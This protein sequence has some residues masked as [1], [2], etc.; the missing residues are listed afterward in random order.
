MKYFTFPCG[1]RFPID[2]SLPPIHGHPSII[3]DPNDIPLDCPITYDLIGEGKTKGVFQ[4]ESPLGRQWAKRAKPRSIE[5]LAA[6]GSLLRPGCLKSRDERGVSMTE[7]YCRY[8]NGEEDIEIDIE[9]VRPILE[10]TY[11]VMCFQEQAM[12]I[13]QVVA[14]FDLLEVDKLRKCVTGD[15]QF[16]S[17][18]RG[19]IS[20]DRLLEE[21][22]E[23]DEFLVMDENGMQSWQQIEKI[24]FTG[25]Q[26][27]LCVRTDS[28]ARV[29]ATKNHQFLTE[30]GWK[31]RMRL[32]E[33]EDTI[34]SARSVSY[35]GQ[36]LITS[37]IAL[38]IAGIVAE[39]YFV[40]DGTKKVA[41]FTNF[42]SL[43]MSVFIE[44]FEN[45]FGKENYWKSEDGKVISIRVPEQKQLENYINRGLSDTRQLPDVMMG[46]TLESTRKF[47][48]YILACEGGVTEKTG[49]FEFSSKSQK[50]ASQI[51][52][53]LLRFG[54]RSILGEYP[55]S[56][57]YRLTVG[58]VEDQKRLLTELTSMWSLTKV[59]PLKVAVSRKINNYTTDTFPTSIV[60]KL[61]NQYPFVGNGE[62]GSLYNKPISRLRL[63][64]IADKTKDG[65]WSSIVRGN[66][67]YDNVKSIGDKRRQTKTYDFTVAGGKTPY[68]IANGMVIHNSIG[69]KD[70]ATLAKVGEL[71][72]K[73]ATDFGVITKEQAEKLFDNMRKSGRY[74][75]NASHAVSY[76]II[77]YQT[78]HLKA[79]FPIQFFTSYLTNARE[80]QKPLQEIR[81]LVNDA[82]SFGFEVLPP[83]FERLD[84]DFDIDGVAIRFGLSDVK[85]VSEAT[86]KK[87]N[88][89]IEQVEATCE[90]HRTLWTWFDYLRF[91]AD[92]AGIGVSRRMIE[93]GALADYKLDRQKM[94]YELE[95]WD[96]LTDKEKGKISTMQTDN[97]MSAI[98]ILLEIPKGVANAKRKEKVV[99]LL[100]T[101]RNPKRPLTDSQSWVAKV[102]EESLG[103]PLTTSHVEGATESIANTTCAEYKAGKKGDN[104]V[105]GVTIEDAREITIKNGDNRGRKMA[106]L[107]VS[108]QTGSLQDV[109][110]FSEA[111][112]RYKN[113][114]VVNNNV[115]LYGR[116][117]FKKDSFIVEMVKLI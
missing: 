87:L 33:G 40:D 29:W 59:K 97:L 81:E 21:G 88:S 79:H 106:F 95:I 54:V 105:L 80:K 42:D 89:S 44:S 57:R 3:Y 52:L 19:W 37:D 13:S 74:L 104:I 58:D 116:R 41:R 108:D 65:Y 61:M 2:E 17:K 24:W 48:S 69:K 50:L 53:L 38:V 32:V 113:E 30:D 14:G 114:I 107:V 34:V 1:C 70:Q 73:K 7:L 51:K 109:C 47:L 77:G 16:V 45:C 112:E 98:E 28:G 20:I 23:D 49:F 93:V 85:G 6:L 103:I 55:E 12:K 43:M 115:D 36:D 101:L 111:Y 90:K 4:L 62:S 75:F 102:E 22:Y 27:A 99:S 117:D 5:H 60:K 10:S 96:K 11:N 31:A 8:K 91:F 66:Q 64:R 9:A 56:E 71:F 84:P 94:L 100:E 82:R 15:T 68:I 110:V 46:M 67:W 63:T 83:K 72:V 39:G 25:K 86:V 18:T 78:A 92:V 35:T 76:A 26:D